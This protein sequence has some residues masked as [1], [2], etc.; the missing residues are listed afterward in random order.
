MSVFFLSAVRL[1]GKVQNRKR[2][3]QKNEDKG[4]ALITITPLPPQFNQT[5]S[6]HPTQLQKLPLLQPTLNQSNYFTYPTQ[7]QSPPTHP[8]QQRLV[9]TQLL[10][11]LRLLPP[12]S[13]A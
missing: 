1:L 3:G 10:L 13:P 11:Q 2:T 6:F 7:L 9:S 12:T 4:K 5:T 8:E